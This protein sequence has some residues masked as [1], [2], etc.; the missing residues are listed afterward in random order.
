MLSNNDSISAD[1]QDMTKALCCKA[2]IVTVFL[3][4]EMHN[5]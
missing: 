5:L 4:K 1:F 3:V 2:G